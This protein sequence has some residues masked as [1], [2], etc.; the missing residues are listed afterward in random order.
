MIYKIMFN[1]QLTFI[2]VGVGENI[3]LEMKDI[4]C[5]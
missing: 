4:N 3:I 1:L 2:R 5:P